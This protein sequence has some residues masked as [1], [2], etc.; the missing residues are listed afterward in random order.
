[1]EVDY[2]SG[3]KYGALISMVFYDD[4]T[5]YYNVISGG[6]V[7]EYEKM[8]PIMLEILKSITLKQ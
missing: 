8:E 1:M 7:S 2:T 6:P 3:D 4:N 5:K